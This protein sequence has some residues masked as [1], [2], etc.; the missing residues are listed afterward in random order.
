MARILVLCGT[1]DIGKSLCEE[2][3]QRHYVICLEHIDIV[4]KNDIYNDRYVYRKRDLL[5]LTP[6]DVST[7]L[8]YVYYILKYEQDSHIKLFKAMN[9]AEKTGAKFIL[10]TTISTLDALSCIILTSMYTSQYNITHTIIHIEQHTG[11]EI[12]L[13]TSFA[14]SNEQGPIKITSTYAPDNIYHPS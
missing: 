1:G 13:L 7:N 3:L 14:E 2:L 8:D 11:P 12:K 9:I 6:Q 10:I 4:S 5:L